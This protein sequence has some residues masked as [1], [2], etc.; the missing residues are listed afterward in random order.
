MRR[1]HEAHGTGRRDSEHAL[2]MLNKKQAEMTYR[3]LGGEI[4]DVL[5][6][7]DHNGSEQDVSSSVKEHLADCKHR[8]G[9][10]G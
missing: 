4:K 5:P 2:K 1:H 8:E 10:S 7:A 3:G 9:E 6:T